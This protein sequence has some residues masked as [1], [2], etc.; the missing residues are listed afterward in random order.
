MGTEIELKL[1]LTE[2]DAA[3]LLEHP[4]VRTP[5]GRRPAARRLSSVYFDTPE[6]DLLHKG[7]A[8]RVRRSGNR[9]IQTVKAEADPSG[10][11]KVTPAAQW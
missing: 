1:G 4:L 10:A 6:L 3:K 11:T 2:G 8:L 5:S 7:V 9:R